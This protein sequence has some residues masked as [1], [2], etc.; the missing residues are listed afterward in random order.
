MKRRTFLA[1]AATGAAGLATGI[2]PAAALEHVGDRRMLVFSGG[3][4]VPLLDPHVKYDWSTRM[5]QQ[6]IYDALAK[7]EGNPPKVVPWLAE[8]WETSRGRPDLDLPPRRQRQVP[9]W[10]SARRRSRALLLRACPEAEQGRRLDAEGPPQAGR[11]QGGG[12]AHHPVHPDGALSR[13]PD[14]H[15]A[16][17]HRQS[18]TNRRQ[19]RQRRLRPEIPHRRRRR[20]RPVQDQALGWPGGHGPRCGRGLLEGLADG[21]RRPTRRRDLPRHPRTRPAQGC[22]ATWRDRHRHRDDAGRLRRDGEDAG[23]RH[24]LEHRHDALHHPDEHPEGRHRRHQFP[25]GAGLRLRL[26]CAV[27]DRE[28]RRDADGQPVPQR[29]DR[30]YRGARHPA[31]Q[32]RPGEAIPGQDQDPAGRHRDRIRSTSPAWR[33][34]AGSAWRCW[35]RCSR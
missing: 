15:A 16:L 28:Q 17:V 12:P 2:Q 35:N 10:R 33:W 6:A 29:D 26:Q 1:G 7:Y 24:Q 5:M 25:Q 14:L 23:H 8:K 9:Q 3:Q 18:E 34:S 22:A 20:L 32:P 31:P 30:P 19:H 13:L 27:A 4:P 11:H 21:R